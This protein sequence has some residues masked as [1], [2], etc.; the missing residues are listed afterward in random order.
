MVGTEL[1]TVE[2]G[3]Q[4]YLNDPRG[5]TLEAERAGVVV[6]KDDEGETRLVIS[7]D[8]ASELLLDK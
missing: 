6:V 3:L 8:R 5:A 7:S 2:I 1:S 4:D